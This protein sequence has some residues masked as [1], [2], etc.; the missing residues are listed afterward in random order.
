MSPAVFGLTCQEERKL[1]VRQWRGR[2]HAVCVSSIVRGTGGIRCDMVCSKC[3]TTV[4]SFYV[5]PQV[6]L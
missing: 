6:W 1:V 4:L 3:E 5:Q 2:A